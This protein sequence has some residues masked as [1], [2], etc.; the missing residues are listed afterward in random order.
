VLAANIMVE[1]TGMELK[2]SATYAIARAGISTAFNIVGLEK[3]SGQNI[4]ITTVSLLVLLNNNS[5]S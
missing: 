1:K 3:S 5:H 2:G 4:N